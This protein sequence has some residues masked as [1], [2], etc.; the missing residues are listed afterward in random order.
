MER[1]IEVQE[2]VNNLK[3]GIGV[4][5]VL[6]ALITTTVVW[7]CLTLKHITQKFAKK[8]ER[9]ISMKRLAMEYQTRL[10]ILVSKISNDG[11]TSEGELK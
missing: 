1:K 3:N 4:A 7:Q 5:L 10:L 11:L 8:T 2:T 6:G 9:N